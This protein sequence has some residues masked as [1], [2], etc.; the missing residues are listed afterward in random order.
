LPEYRPADL[1]PSP[2]VTDIILFSLEP[3]LPVIRLEPYNAL[4]T[5][6]WYT[7]IK[8]T[9]KKT[10]NIILRHFDLEFVWD[11]TG[12]GRFLAYYGKII[13]MPEIL[14]SVWHCSAGN[15]A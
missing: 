4:S 1:V 8:I 5:I 6:Q 11:Q 14:M 3:I 10:I 2:S 9:G 13:L 7:P 12:N 15:P